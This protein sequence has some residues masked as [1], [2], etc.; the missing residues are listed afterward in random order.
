MLDIK[1]VLNLCKYMQ[2]L[3]ITQNSQ[4]KPDHLVNRI[5]LAMAVSN[6][7]LNIQYLALPYIHTMAGSLLIVLLIIIQEIKKIFPSSI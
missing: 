7:A 1:K 6:I 3:K 2:A 5:F 4:K